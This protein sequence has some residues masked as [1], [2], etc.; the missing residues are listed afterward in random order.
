MAGKAVDNVAKREWWRNFG[1]KMRTRC[2]IDVG[3]LPVLVERKRIKNMYLR[4]QPPMGRVKVTAPFGA[5]DAEIA[6]LVREKWGWIQTHQARMRTDEALRLAPRHF[7]DGTTFPIFSKHVQVHVDPDAR[8]ARLVGDQLIVPGRDVDAEVTKF[9]KGHLRG[10]ICELL[11]HW[12]PVVG[13]RPA[14]VSIRKMTSRWGS[15]RKDRATMSMNL[16][17]VFLPE[18]YLSYV[19]VHEL[20][21]LWVPGHGK[22]FYRRMD[23]YLPQ[24]KRLRR[25]L[26]EL[27]G[28]VL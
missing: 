27:G 10:R 18:Q 7:E 22:E 11:D 12:G 19:L 13:R 25:E 15:C 4:V 17:L 8:R 23:S 9:L 28:R 2:V 24:W 14:R 21:H 5:R 16:A 20:T 26:N 3:P 6:D 1:R